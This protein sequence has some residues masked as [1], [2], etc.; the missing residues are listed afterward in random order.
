MKFLKEHY[1]QTNLKLNQKYSELI[2]RDLDPN[3]SKNYDLYSPISVLMLINLLSPEEL[4][5]ELSVL[6][7]AM[8]KWISNKYTSTYNYDWVA[9]QICRSYILNGENKIINESNWK[10][11]LIEIFKLISKDNSEREIKKIYLLLY[12]RKY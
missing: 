4:E 6:A 12:S 11:L 1:S 5:N 8:L 7:P 2:L 9:Y 10:R 3:L